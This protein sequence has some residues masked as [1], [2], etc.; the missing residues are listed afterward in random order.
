M[1]L[2]HAG[3][4]PRLALTHHRAATAAGHGAGFL[5]CFLL[6]TA[7]GKPAKGC[8][9]Q[10][11]AHVMENVMAAAERRRASSGA[12]PAGQPCTWSFD[13][14]KIHQKLETLI[15]LKI[16]HKN[17]FPLPPNSPDMHRVVERCIGRLKT[18]FRKWM[19]AHPT[20]RTMQQYQQALTTLFF[21]NK[22]IAGSTALTKDVKKLPGLFKEI[23]AAKGSWPSKRSL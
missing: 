15:A 5:P 13:N 17:R 11:W 8:T 9:N 14:D 7:A 19:Y 3:G 10:E 20:S 12:W 6:Q 18:A 16:N 2:P 23:L 21:T 4:G 22:Q 1:F